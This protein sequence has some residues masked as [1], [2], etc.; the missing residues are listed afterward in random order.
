MNC[1]L[2]KGGWTP[3]HVTPDQLVTIDL[4]AEGIF[5]PCEPYFDKFKQYGAELNVPPLILASFA[6]QESGCN[7]HLGGNGG[8]AGMMQLGQE[9]CAAAQ[10]QGM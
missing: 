10:Q 1:G 6:L 8:E 3:P 7:P 4:S 2:D 5:K 9:N